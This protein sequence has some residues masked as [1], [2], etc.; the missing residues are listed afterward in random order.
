MGFI[1]GE[2]RDRRFPREQPVAD[3]NAGMIRKTRLHPDAAH[4]EF[5]FFQFLDLQVCREFLESDG[6]ERV[7][8][9]AGKHAAEAAASALI[10][11][12]AHAVLR[13]IEGLE[14]RQALDM[15]PVRVRQKQRDVQ[16]LLAE[17]LRQLFAQETQ[18]C[19]GVQN[20]QLAFRAYLDA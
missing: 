12:N 2:I 14:K 5:H 17:L 6:K 3:A 8:H 15:V 18:A 13:L 1:V 11:E 20:D 19:A 10:T 16:R 4:R 7:L 9:L